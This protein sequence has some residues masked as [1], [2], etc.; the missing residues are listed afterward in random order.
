[1]SGFDPLATS[2]DAG[3]IGY[4]N[5]IYDSIMEFG[6]RTESRVIDIGCGTGLAAAP[7]L[8]AGFSVTGVDVSESMLDKARARMAGAHWVAGEATALPFG[9]QTFDVAISAQTFHWFDR[10]KAIAEMA[11]VL[12]PGGVAAI[13]WKNFTASE[14]IGK[15]RV[16]VAHDMGVTLPESKFS[17]GFREFYGSTLGQK[18]LRVLPWQIV[19]PQA[20]YLDYERSRLSLREALGDRHEEYISLLA[21]RVSDLYGGASVPLSYIQYL[22]LGKA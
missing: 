21:S 19:V 14:P 7:L 5:A 1:M 22:Y 15:L 4:S 16:A 11:R 12:T 8:A 13:W 17:G 2:Y 6:A 18:R 3:R 10:T 9:A 20:R